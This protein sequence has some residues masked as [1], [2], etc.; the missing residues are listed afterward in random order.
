MLQARV[1]LYRQHGATNAY[2]IGLPG[3]I[4]R[5]CTI[6]SCAQ[7]STARPQNYGQQYLQNQ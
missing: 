5:S 7:A 2:S 1:L 3:R 6:R 4:K